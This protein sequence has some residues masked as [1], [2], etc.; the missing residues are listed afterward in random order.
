MKNN[1]R[2]VTII[3]GVA[4]GALL[5]AA[6]LPAA[7]AFA[8]EYDFTPDTTTFI[9]TQAEGYPPLFNEITG[10]ESWSV[11]DATTGTATALSPDVLQGIDT[12]TT[13]GS[14]T[15]D[16]FI[17]SDGPGQGV[18]FDHHGVD[19]FNVLGHVQI[20]LA[21]FGGGFENEWIDLP[22]GSTD[23]GVSD[24][25]ITPFGDY[26]LAGSAFSDFSASIADFL[27]AN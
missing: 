2:R 20:D 18:L 24:L 15:N 7:V 8:D 23:P 9:P 21:N 25:L 26:A 17:S 10:T 13:F 27:G 3:G 14:F 6:L 4:A 11:L 16:D 5:A 12:T 22:S 1:Q 19:P